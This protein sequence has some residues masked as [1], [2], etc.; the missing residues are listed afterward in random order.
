MVPGITG[1]AQRSSLL[2]DVRAQSRVSTHIFFVGRRDS[3]LFSRFGVRFLGNGHVVE[4]LIRMRLF[5]YNATECAG[6]SSTHTQ[7]HTCQYFLSILP[8]VCKRFR[9]LASDPRTCIYRDLAC[10]TMLTFFL[11]VAV[12]LLRQLAPY[13]LTQLQRSFELFHHT[14]GSLRNFRDT[15]SLYWKRSPYYN[16][17]QHLRASLQEIDHNHSI[18]S[19]CNPSTRQNEPLTQSI[20][21]TTLRK[22]NRSAE[23]R[24][25]M[26]MTSSQAPT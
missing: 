20:A 26:V 6:N 1:S 4:N 7:L 22:Q 15:H 19:K 2:R 17:F 10:G 13:Q 18:W 8:L 5:N 16:Q 23:V 11:F 25:R 12:S 21:A 24:D 14:H 3:R 9:K